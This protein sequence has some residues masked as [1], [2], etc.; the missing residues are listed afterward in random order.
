MET[1]QPVA[2]ELAQ[3]ISTAIAVSIG[4]GFTVGAVF[5][6]GGV[7]LERIATSF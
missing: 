4:V 5:V 2:T 6:A 3:V 1:Q 7:L